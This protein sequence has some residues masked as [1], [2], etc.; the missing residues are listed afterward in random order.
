MQC[1]PLDG[2]KSCPINH[3][4]TTPET[5]LQASAQMTSE[6]YSMS[7]F[8]V[9]IVEEAC[10]NQSQLYFDGGVVLVVITKNQSSSLYSLQAYNEIVHAWPVF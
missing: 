8:C 4:K 2:R 9:K 7:C 3:G 10:Y 6:K 1:C 5:F